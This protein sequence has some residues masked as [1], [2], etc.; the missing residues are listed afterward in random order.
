MKYRLNGNT[1]MAVPPPCSFHLCFNSIYVKL[2]DIDCLSSGTHLMDEHPVATAERLEW[3]YLVGLYVFVSEMM[4]LLMFV[5][6]RL[7]FVKLNML[8]IER[9]CFFYLGRR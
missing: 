2:T 6:T 3:R 8:Q 4:A 1:I 7:L 9:S 5:L